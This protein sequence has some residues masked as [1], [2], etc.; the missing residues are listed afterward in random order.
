[1][2]LKQ[3]LSNVNSTDLGPDGLLTRVLVRLELR[4]RGFEADVDILIGSSRSGH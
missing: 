2:I 4:R 1:M 3:S